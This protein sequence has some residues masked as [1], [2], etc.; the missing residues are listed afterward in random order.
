MQ[1]VVE[2]NVHVADQR[3]CY[4]LLV[5]ISEILQPYKYSIYLLNFALLMTHFVQRIPGLIGWGKESV[6][7][8]P[9]NLRP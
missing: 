8:W 5:K 9:L 6:G 1:S 2:L 7:S 3:I 4:C